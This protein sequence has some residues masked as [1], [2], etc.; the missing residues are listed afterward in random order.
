VRNHY[1]DMKTQVL[2]RK[3]RVIDCELKNPSSHNHHRWDLDKIAA[4]VMSQSARNGHHNHTASSKLT[5]KEIELGCGIPGRMMFL[6][7]RNTED[8]YHGVP[9]EWIWWLFI[10][11]AAMLCCFLAHLAIVRLD[12]SRH[13]VKENVSFIL[14][15]CCHFG[16]LQITSPILLNK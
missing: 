15:A 16:G 3:R 6:S 2:W 12:A 14:P 1:S 13:K 10:E 4:I 5:R 11:L 8:L 9:S 7:L